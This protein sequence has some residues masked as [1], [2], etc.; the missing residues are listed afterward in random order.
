MTERNDHLARLQERLLTKEQALEKIQG[1]EDCSERLVR[2]RT[3]FSIHPSLDNHFIMAHEETEFVF[4][5]HGFEKICRLV[6]VPQTYTRKI[7]AQLL[8]PHLQYWLNDGEVGMKAF[9]RQSP[10]DDGRLPV[11]GF[12]HE[13]AYY[14]PISR[15]LNRVD[16]VSENYMVEGFEDISWRHSDFGLVFPDTQFEITTPEVGDHLYGGVKVQHSLLGET[17]VKIS[18]FLLTLACLNGMVSVDEIYT[19]N[20]K[21][22]FEGEDEWIVTGV[23]NAIGALQSEVDKVRR[24]TSIPITNEEIPP[25]VSHAFD[26]RGVNKKTREAVLQQ[27]IARNPRNLYELMNAIT[28]VAHTIENRREVLAVQSLGGFVA[29]HSDSCNNC[30]RPF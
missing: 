18:A 3:E 22:G 1:Y 29:S 8:F 26:Q 12:A 11:A 13:D 20:R 19:F 7:P 15:I 4:N 24:L 9:M 2:G 17:P 16:E 30:H 28:E 23:Q 25:Y 21:Q 5:Q 14:Y 6:G 27:I 10:D